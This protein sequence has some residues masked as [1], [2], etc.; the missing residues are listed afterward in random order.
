MWSK[1]LVIFLFLTFLISF[2]AYSAFYLRIIKIP[3][4]FS[5]KKVEF[6]DEIGIGDI[7]FQKEAFEKLAKELRLWDRGV[8]SWEKNILSLQEDDIIIPDKIFIILTP[9][10]QK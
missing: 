3:P 6:V 8:Y 7:R 5:S 4:Q 1:K 10:E 2:I 9:N